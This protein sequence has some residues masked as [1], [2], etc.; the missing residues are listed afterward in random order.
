MF[1]DIELRAY[2][3][4]TQFYDRTIIVDLN[5]LRNSELKK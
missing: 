4:D 1:L 3:P 2:Y 5:S